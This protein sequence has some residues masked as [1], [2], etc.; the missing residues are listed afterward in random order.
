M[1][2]LRQRKPRRFM[3]LTHGHDIL[4]FEGNSQTAKFPLPKEDPQWLN[5]R[6]TL[7]PKIKLF[8]AGTKFKHFDGLNANDYKV[9]LILFR[10]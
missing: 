10:L 6:L 1:E 5:F 8:L 2:A 4:G 7:I 9:P 3:Q